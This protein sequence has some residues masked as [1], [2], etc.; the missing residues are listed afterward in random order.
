MRTNNR[1]IL[2]FLLV[3]IIISL[4]CTHTRH[5]RVRRYLFKPRQTA[6][7]RFEPDTQGQTK[8]RE[9]PKVKVKFQENPK[10]KARIWKCARTPTVLYYLT[11]QFEEI[12]VLEV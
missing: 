12:K 10:I 5:T 11:S 8:F 9:N 2:R 4:I 6:Q 1:T 3:G 7:N